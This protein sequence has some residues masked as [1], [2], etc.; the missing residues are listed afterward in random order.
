[1]SLIDNNNRFRYVGIDPGT[2]HL[3][4]AIIDYDVKQKT[5][6]LV[7]ASTIHTMKLIRRHEDLVATHGS[8]IAKLHLIRYCMFEFFTI[9]QP[10]SVSIEYPF[11]GRF[12]AAF[13]S[14]M[15]AVT[16]IRDA[17]FQYDT[18][19]TL[20]QVDPPTIKKTVGAKGNDKVDMAKAVPK[21]ANLIN[22][23][24]HDYSAYDDHSIDA[25]AVAYWSAK[26]GLY[27]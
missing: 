7:H 15:E 17:L 20:D 3:G 18:A 9:W 11:S 5:L 24:N 16:V 8:K 2:D 25:V 6:H 14:L 10:N 21:L 19:L 23:T 4:R 13:G 12:P 27:V 1:M 26:Q 22:D